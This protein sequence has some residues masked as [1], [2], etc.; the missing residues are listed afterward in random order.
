MGSQ[1]HGCRGIGS[2][3]AEGMDALE[4]SS[5]Q[6]VEVPKLALSLG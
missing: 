5:S 2:Y 3:E 1:D 6:W 4:G